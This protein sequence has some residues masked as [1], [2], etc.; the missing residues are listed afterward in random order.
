MWISWFV[1]ISVFNEMFTKRSINPVVVQRAITCDSRYK[2]TLD[3]Y[4]VRLSGNYSSD[5]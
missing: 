3:P 2:Q 5:R 4:L 1:V